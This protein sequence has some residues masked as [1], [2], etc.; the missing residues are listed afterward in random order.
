M[1][2]PYA[3]LAG[4]EQDPYAGLAVEHPV[5]SPGA[6]PK[7]SA[8]DQGNT[9]QVANPFGKNL[10]T[11]IPIPASVQNLL[12]G[13]GETFSNAGTAIKQ[14]VASL[15]G[16]SNKSL[17]GL[18]TGDDPVAEQ[19]AR[20]AELNSTWAGTIGRALP[21][22]GAAAVPGMQTV[23]GGAAIGGLSGLLDPTTGNESALRNT[24]IG[25]ALGAAGAGVGNKIA[26]WAAGRA[27]QPF[28]GWSRDTANRAA[29][30]A[31]GSDAAKLDQP[32]IAD[33][34]QRFTQIFGAARNPAVTVPVGAPTAAEIGRVA[35]SAGNS[36]TRQAF[37]ASDAV[38][39]LMAQLRSGSANAQQLGKISSDLGREAAA[40]M[41][42]KSGDRALGRA[43]FDLQDHVDQLV[44]NSI[45][46]PALREAYT[47][48]VPQYRNFLTLTRRPSLLNSATGDVNPPNLGRYLQRADAG[49][50]NGT[51]QSSF[52]N[53][54]RWGQATGEGRG[55]PPFTLGN[56]GIPFFAH[57]VS[58]SLPGRAFGGVAANTLARAPGAVRALPQGLLGGGTSPLLEQ[59]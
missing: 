8:V 28:M 55:A 26:G 49:Y 34:G 21:A 45:T 24:L 16:Q 35:A 51:N 33:A 20:D 29:A 14:R 12:A 23:A 36:S 6:Q 39:D 43:L 40:Q 56:L 30:S 57:K 25:G 32:A 9:L 47:A 10:D 52:Y 3:G 5:L 37:Q 19:R 1:S 41:G 27:A 59:F 38:Q 2:D 53:M 48:A 18:I 31:V 58:N 7:Y 4:A 46:D 42:N 15:T 13:A 44:G 11:G 22:L 17:S 54:A 50:R